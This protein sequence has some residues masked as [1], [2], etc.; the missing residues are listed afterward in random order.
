MLVWVVRVVDEYKCAR[1]YRYTCSNICTVIRSI[2]WN[3]CVFVV[4]VE[5]ENVVEMLPVNPSA[6]VTQP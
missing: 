5:R 4:F 3:M 6:T 1:T 2:H